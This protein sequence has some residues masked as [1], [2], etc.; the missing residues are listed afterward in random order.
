MHEIK[1][2]TLAGNNNDYFSEIY[3]QWFTLTA[4]E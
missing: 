4:L 2:Q 3:H 1:S